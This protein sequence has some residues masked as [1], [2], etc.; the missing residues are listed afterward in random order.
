[1]N[2][3]KTWIKIQ[4]NLLELEKRTNRIKDQIRVME[5]NEINKFKVESNPEYSTLF[6]LSMIIDGFI[7][8][9]AKL[10]LADIPKFL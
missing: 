7:F 8:L 4:K 9:E 2:K 3:E 6:N 5:I 10:T 1:M